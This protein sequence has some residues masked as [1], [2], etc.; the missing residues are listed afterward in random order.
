MILET[1]KKSLC[2]SSKVELRKKYYA[3]LVRHVGLLKGFTIVSLPRASTPIRRA[4][5]SM[6]FGIKVHKSVNTTY[7][8]KAAGAAAT[9]AAGKAAGAAAKSATEGNLER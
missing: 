8:G 6:G 2:T 4:V 7:A 5:E 1:G 9:S 3:Y